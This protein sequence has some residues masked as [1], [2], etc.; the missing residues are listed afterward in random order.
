MI[1]NKKKNCWYLFLN[2][3]VC[4]I[5]SIYDGEM[6][7]IKSHLLLNIILIVSI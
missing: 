4:K 7:I 2:I 1:E 6:Q 5:I 3:L